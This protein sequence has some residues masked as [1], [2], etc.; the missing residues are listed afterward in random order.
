MGPVAAF[1]TV[2]AARLVV[3]Q[4]GDRSARAHPDLAAALGPA[5]GGGTVEGWRAPVQTGGWLAWH[6]G[7]LRRRGRDDSQHRS[8]GATG[9][10]AGPRADGRR[11]PLDAPGEAFRGGRSAGRGGYHGR[12]EDRGHGAIRAGPSA[13]SLRPSRLLARRLRVARPHAPRAGTGAKARPPLYVGTTRYSSS[14]RGHVADVADDPASLERV[15]RNE[16]AL[17]IHPERVRES[18]FV[19]AIVAVRLRQGPAVYARQNRACMARPDSR[20]SFPA[21]LCP[22]PRCLHVV[23]STALTSS[24]SARAAAMTCADWPPRSRTV[25]G[26]HFDLQTVVAIEAEAS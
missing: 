20:P 10:R 26:H 7:G 23:G 9:A 5:E 17:V 3:E 2:D 21:I 4:L 8:T 1:P 15:I 14:A 16:I 6:V 13:R 18:A 25:T 24:A 12:G 11:L 22:T 19:E